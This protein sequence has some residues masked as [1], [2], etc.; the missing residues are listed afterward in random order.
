MNPN[1]LFGLCDHLEKPSQNGDPLE[2]LVATVDFE[3]LRPRLFR[4]SGVWRWFQRQTSPFDPVSMFKV[5]ILQ[6]RHNLSAARMAFMVRDRLSWVR[7]VGF[8]LEGALPD[9]NTIRHFR[10]HVSDTGTLERV[11]E[12]FDEQLHR[13][14]LNVKPE[15]RRCAGVCPQAAQHRGGE[16][17][18]QG[19]QIR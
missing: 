5:L 1:S 11:M 8:Q 18:N 14:Y 19:R 6:A 12:A 7:L 2:T 4:G 15:R 10:N 17:G 3:Y 9:E 16:G 13:V